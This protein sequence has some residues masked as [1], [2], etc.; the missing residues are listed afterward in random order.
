MQAAIT[1]FQGALVL[2]CATSG[3]LVLAEVAAGVSTG[4]ALLCEHSNRSIPEPN[5]SLSL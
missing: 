1:A 3:T 4:Q 2:T 5:H